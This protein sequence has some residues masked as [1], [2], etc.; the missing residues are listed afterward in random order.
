KDECNFSYR[1]SD[2][3]KN[4]YVLLEAEFRLDKGDT[5]ALKKEVNE[6]LTIRLKKYKPGIACP[7]S[8]FKNV[9]VKDLSRQQ[10]EKIPKEK[11][12][13]EKIP[14]GYLLEEVGAKGAKKGEIE[15]AAFHANLFMNKG[16]GT[17]QDF[18]AL[19]Q[20]F[21]QKVKEKFGIELESEVQLIGFS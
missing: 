4:K 7:G 14:A 5:E 10:L 13:Y 19:S 8:F 11:I 2:F 16:K 15:I 3:K 20:E 9:Q 1:D 6:T 21:R 12:V 17:S 18:F